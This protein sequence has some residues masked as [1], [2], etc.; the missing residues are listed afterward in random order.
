M[1]L[2]QRMPGKRSPRGPVCDDN[3]QLRIMF[4]A[5]ISTVIITLF[6]FAIKGTWVNEGKEGTD[7]S[8]SIVLRQ[9]FN[10][11]R[12]IPS[13]RQAQDRSLVKKRRSIRYRRTA[14][15]NHW[16]N[17]H[18][19]YH[20]ENG[21]VVAAAIVGDVA[22]AIVGDVAEAIVGDVAEAIVGDVAEAIVGDVAEAIVGDVAAAIVCVVVAAAIVSVVVA[23]AIESVV[24]AA[25]IVS[26]VVAAAIE[27]VVVAAAIVS[28]VVAAAIVSVV[29]AAAIVS[30][31]VA[32]A[33]V[34]V[35][36]V[37]AIVA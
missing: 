24:V 37:A 36:V 9:D 2:Y 7:N 35:V 30:V 3:I 12:S 22:E 33:I 6:V 34:S 19:R 27:S 20:H 14:V 18:G 1:I 25:A 23:A 13:L 17:D 11:S 15:L 5:F 16:A 10:N 31:V 8:S 29:V 26:V 4:P 28:V 21:C 32:A